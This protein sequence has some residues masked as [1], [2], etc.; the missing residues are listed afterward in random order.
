MRIGPMWCF[1][2]KWGTAEVILEKCCCTNMTTFHNIR[3]LI[4]E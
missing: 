4:A 3:M 2:N 1:K